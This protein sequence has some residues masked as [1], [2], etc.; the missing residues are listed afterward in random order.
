MSIMQLNQRNQ[1]A[2]P[3]SILTHSGIKP[4][5]Y[6][7]IV[8]EEGGIFLRPVAIVEENDFLTPEE[9]DKLDTLVEKQ[10]QAGEYTEYKSLD[11]ARGH[12]R[13]RMKKV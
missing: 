7:K 10:L 9:W 12:S 2:I 11:E 8:E 13:R 3:R 4:G 5:D 6:V 1:V